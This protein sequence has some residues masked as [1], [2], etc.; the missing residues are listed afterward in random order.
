M[1]KGVSH[2]T[3]PISEAGVPYEF[4]NVY[5]ILNSKVPKLC[6][7]E[8]IKFS[9]VLYALCIFLVITMLLPSKPK[10]PLCLPP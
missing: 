6:D 9:I 10:I 8:N 2:N 5:H 7:H 3:I 1:P 4:G